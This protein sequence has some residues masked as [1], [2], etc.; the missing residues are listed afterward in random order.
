MTNGHICG[1]FINHANKTFSTTARPA[2]EWHLDGMERTQAAQGFEF[3]VLGRGLSK[4]KALEL[5]HC[6]KAALGLVGYTHVRRQATDQE[7]E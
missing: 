7:E 3:N 4:G 2:S 1:V 6:V 5:K